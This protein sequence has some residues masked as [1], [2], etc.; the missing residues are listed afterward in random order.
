MLTQP[1]QRNSKW[2]KVLFSALLL[3][4]VAALAVFL[5]SPDRH[6][7]VEPQEITQEAAL[8]I[9]PYVLITE[10]EYAYIDR[11][12]ADKAV[13]DALANTETMT[14]LSDEAAA[15][16]ADEFFI[17]GE[18]TKNFTIRAMDGFL[19]VSAETDDRSCIFIHSSEGELGK[20]VGQYYTTKNFFGEKVKP[21][22]LLENYDNTK[23]IENVSK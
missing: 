17:D 7:E 16:Y 22:F 21:V 14:T 10:E 18:A 4:A 13:Q 20:I 11:I 12:L 8:R 3:G 6:F 9:C 19:Y 2:M 23:F 1:S 5:L 15:D